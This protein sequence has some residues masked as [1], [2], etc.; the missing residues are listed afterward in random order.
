MKMNK[1]QF[2]GL[3][4]RY[5]NGLASPAET[6][7]LD[8]FFNSYRTSSGDLPALNEEIKEAMF[9]NIEVVTGKNLRRRQPYRVAVWL[10]AAAVVSFLL[11]ASYVVINYVG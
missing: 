8:Q 9:Q 7:L 10:R 11:I 6:K 5:L 1:A 3:L 2:Q 4:D